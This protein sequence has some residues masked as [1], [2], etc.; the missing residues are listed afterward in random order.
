MRTIY[1]DDDCAALGPC[2]ATIGFFDGVH[3]G[4]RYLINSI[5]GEA[6][7]TPGMQSTVIT[8]DR[9]PRQVLQKE[10]QPKLLTTNEEKLTLLSKTGIDNCVMLHFD[11]DMAALSARSFMESILRDRLRVRKLIIGYDHRFGHNRSEGF[12]D[13]VRY[14]RKLG[15]EVVRSNAFVLNDVNVSSSVIRA[16]LSEGEAGMAAMCLGYPYFL[17]GR[18]VG[19]FREGRKIGFPTA[20]IEIGD[21]SKLV[22]LPGVYAVRIRPESLDGMMGGMMNIGTR[23]TFGGSGITLEVNIFGFEGDIY[24]RSVCIQLVR[25]LRDER[26]FPSVG[27]LVEQLEQDKVAAEQVLAEDGHESSAQQ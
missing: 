2:V 5:I 4:H 10:F 12:D 23:P 1:S 8:F 14:G 21:S 7:K 22:P 17:T 16:F 18:V 9:H 6:G 25:R 26:K 13:Y 11:R 19:G 24:G 3:R 27:R 20:N 15:I